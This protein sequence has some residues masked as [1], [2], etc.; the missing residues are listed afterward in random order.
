MRLQQC[1]IVT[2]L[3]SCIFACS[4]HKPQL[5]AAKQQA[6]EGTSTK[7]RRYSLLQ[8]QGPDTDIDV[9]KIPDAA[10]KS[11]PRTIA[12]NMSPYTVL[13]KSYAIQFDTRGFSQTGYASWYGKKFHGERTSNGEIYNMFAMT[14]AHKTLP[15]PCYV[16]VTNLDNKKAVILRV[17][18]RGPFHDDRVIDLTYTAAK[19]LGFHAMGTARV[20]VDVLNVGD[21]PFPPVAK[22]RPLVATRNAVAPKVVSSAPVAAAMAK[23]PEAKNMELKTATTSAALPPKQNPDSL[24]PSYLQVGSFG[25]QAA[26]EGLQKSLREFTSYP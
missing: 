14:A 3:S 4:T 13:G 21:A 2:I 7:K 10:P 9:S 24:T 12:G 16:R 17:N 15:I 1:L 26:A 8:D 23:V 19:K 20:Q 11:E 5:I 18:D 22:F 6:E 25:S